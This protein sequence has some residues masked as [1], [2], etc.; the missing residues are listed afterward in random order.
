MQAVLA[1]LNFALVNG[2]LFAKDDLATIAIRE[3]IPLLNHQA[4]T[5]IL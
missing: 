4:R 1:W 5:G 3:G 2:E